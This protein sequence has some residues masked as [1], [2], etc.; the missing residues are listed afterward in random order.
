[1]RTTILCLLT[2]LFVTVQS[3]LAGLIPGFEPVWEKYRRG[4]SSQASGGGAA[5]RTWT[6]PTTGM[7]FVFVKG[8]CF[9]MGSN[10]GDKSARPVHEVCLDDFYLGKYEVTQGEW[11]K[12]VGKNPANFKKGDF[13][14]VENVS[15]NDVQ[16]YIRQLNQLNTKI[17]RL[18]TEAEWEYAAR[19]GGK[20]EEYS[21]GN[22]AD[23]VAWYS[24]NSGGKTHPVGQKQPNG[25][26]FYDMSGNVYEWC[27]DWYR[28]GYYSKSPRNNPQ[29]PSSGGFNLFEWGLTKVSRG[30]S[31]DSPMTFM[32]LADRGWFGRSNKFNDVGF[33]LSF[34]AK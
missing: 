8:G 20:K 34:P 3:T 19:S 27:S 32:R 11:S 29:G 5:G 2:S 4:A 23:V 31:W 9:M 1:M 18:P 26:G 6:D 25:L 33:R 14:P 13:Y 22:N 24:G 12:V 21:G 15:W 7:E 16:D 30:G 17:Y 28:E 10:M